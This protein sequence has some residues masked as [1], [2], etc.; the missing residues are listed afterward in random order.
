MYN[1][2]PLLFYGGEGYRL[3]IIDNDRMYE[4]IGWLVKNPIKQ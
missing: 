4:L 2:L 1:V 3:V